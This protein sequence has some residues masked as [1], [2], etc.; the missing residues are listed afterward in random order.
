MSNTSQKFRIHCLLN[1]NNERSGNATSSISGSADDLQESGQN[2]RAGGGG[3]VAR[4]LSDPERMNKKLISLFQGILPV[5]S[6]TV[7]SQRDCGSAVECALPSPQWDAFRA[8]QTV[9]STLDGC[10]S[11]L[12]ANNEHTHKHT[13]TM[14]CTLKK[15]P[16]SSFV[17]TIEPSCTQ[18]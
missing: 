7:L 18:S 9:I 14:T 3:D 5:M 6:Q 4:V 12:N 17:Q 13:P 10:S 8:Y 2:E 11:S 1:Q 16:Q 15:S